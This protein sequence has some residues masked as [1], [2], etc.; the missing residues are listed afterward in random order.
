MIAELTRELKERD[1]A[2]EVLPHAHTERASDEAKVLGVPIGDVGKTLVVVTPEG[3]ARAVVPATERLDLHKVRDALGGGK[4][5]RLATEEELKDAYPMFELGAVPPVGGPRD[6][7]L[8]DRRLAGRESIV[9]EA[10][11]HD[12]SVRVRAEDLLR[13]ADAEILDLVI[14]D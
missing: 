4:K 12:E 7:V 14:E 6:R 13:A 3:R 8:V 5:V 9:V 10:G 11:T 2:F 1:V